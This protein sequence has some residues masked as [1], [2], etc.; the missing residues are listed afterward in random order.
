MLLEF[1]SQQQ[2]YNLQLP[3]F[4][5]LFRIFKFISFCR[6]ALGAGHPRLFLT[7]GS[8]F[9]LYSTFKSF[10]FL[11]CRKLKKYITVTK[12]YFFFFTSTGL[13][14][15]SLK[16]KIFF[17]FNILLYYIIKIAFPMLNHEGTLYK[18]HSS[19]MIFLLI[20]C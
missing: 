4:A 9:F 15:L 10:L 18:P 13:L 6:L 2:L 19:K 14:A 8:G 5:F 3:T 11:V 16:I 1:L 12:F 17:S 7:K 20:P